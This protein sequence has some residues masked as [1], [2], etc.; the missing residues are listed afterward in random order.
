MICR[1]ARQLL[2]QGPE[3]LTMRRK[4][5]LE[6]HLESCP[7]CRKAE[8]S[9][10]LFARELLCA[11]KIT[12]PEEMSS[13]LWPSVF[14]QI[15]ATHVESAHSLRKRRYRLKVRFPVWVYPSLATACA[16][17]IIFLMHPWRKE[18]IP[19]PTSACWTTSTVQHAE[20]DGRHARV[21]IFQ[22]DNP[23][24]TFIWL[25]ENNEINGG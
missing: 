22:T 23:N 20:I 2:A 15:H 1:T 8:E 7:K 19:V 9:L 10:N 12:L 4:N 16:L 24:M 3:H 14:A 13:T 11:R 17:A 21:S 6:H 25:E 18:L 5:R